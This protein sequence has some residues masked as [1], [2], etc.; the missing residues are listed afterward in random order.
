MYDIRSCAVLEKL[1]IVSFCLN[2]GDSENNRCRRILTVFCV[3]LALLAYLT[4]SKL[5]EARGAVIKVV[6]G[7]SH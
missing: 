7:V 2:S 5:N 1:W 6:G 3:C 4:W